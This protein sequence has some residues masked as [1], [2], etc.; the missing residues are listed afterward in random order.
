VQATYE[1]QFGHW[2][3]PTHW[4]TSWDVA[5]FEVCG[6]KWADLSESG[7]G[8]SLL[9]D[10]KFGYATHGNVMR[11]SLL[12]SPKHPD[13]VADMGTQNFRY[14]LFPHAGSFQESGTIQ[15]AYNF[16]VPLLTRQ[17]CVSEVAK[18]F[19]SVDNQSIIIE[20]VKRAEDNDKEI[21][22]RLYE[23]HGGRC[24][25]HLHSDLPV[26]RIAKVDMLEEELE[27]GDKVTWENGG[28]ALSVK[29]FEILSLKLQF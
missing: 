15:Q 4:N 3:R 24:K 1:I 10:S 29:P 8:V 11:L 13:P 27:N 12:R 17:L 16:N 21:V 2:Q 14:A 25:F 18:S 9:N 6:H 20:T 26:K 28:V 23:S 19:F 22:L 5:K 7:Y